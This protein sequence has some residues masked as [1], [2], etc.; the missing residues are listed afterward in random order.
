MFIIKSIKSKCFSILA[1][2]LTTPGDDETIFEYEKCKKTLFHRQLFQ[3][4]AIFEA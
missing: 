3:N 2:S 1:N 4:A